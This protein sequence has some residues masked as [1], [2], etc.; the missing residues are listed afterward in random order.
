MLLARSGTRVRAYTTRET[1]Y[2]PKRQYTTGQKRILV[3]GCMGQ[4]GSE[5]VPALR[6][7]HGHDN[8]FAT[9]IFSRGVDD[10][11]PFEYLD[12]LDKTSLD[13]TI[14]NKNI[15]TIIHL[16]GVLSAKGET[17]IH[18]G[19]A[20]NIRGMENIMLAS[21][22][23]KCSLFAPSSIAAFGPSSPLVDT[24]N[25][26]F[27]RPTTIYGIAKVYTEN[28]GEYWHKKVG[29]DFRCLRYPGIISHKTQPGGG[30]TDWAVAIY[31]GAVTVRNGVCFHCL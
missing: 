12:I 3:T 6:N 2:R 14:V 23:H 8:V 28:M 9:D 11:G 10:E 21:V 20:V 19:M 18:A 22:K 4:I 24:P 31:H 30:T 17:D 15:N 13:R 5:L 27:M 1:S 29:L 25:E 7:I 26:C 16:S